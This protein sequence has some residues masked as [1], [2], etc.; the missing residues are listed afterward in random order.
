MTAS[1]HKRRFDARPQTSGLTLMNRHVAASRQ[2]KRWARC[3]HS[4]VVQ[5]DAYEHR[6]SVKRLSRH[7]RRISAY[8]RIV[9]L[10]ANVAGHAPDRRTEPYWNAVPDNPAAWRG[11][12]C[13]YTHITGCPAYYDARSPGRE[14]L[15]SHGG[16]CKHG[17]RDQSSRQELDCS[18]RTCPFSP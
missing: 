8:P 16:R 11:R 7:G 5:F 12:N 3:R 1:G 4:T 10:V 14:I 13:P 15:A 9:A 6:A 17:D 2:R 18:H